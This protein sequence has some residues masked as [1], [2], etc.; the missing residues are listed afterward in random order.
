M[1]PSPLSLLWP[2]ILIPRKLYF[3]ALLGNHSEK[4]ATKKADCNSAIIWLNVQFE[5]STDPCLVWQWWCSGTLWS[6][7]RCW[8]TMPDVEIDSITLIS[9]VLTVK[10]KRGRCQEWLQYPLQPW[11]ALFPP[12]TVSFQKPGG[13]AL[14]RGAAEPTS[15]QMVKRSADVWSSLLGDD[16][17]A[18]IRTTKAEET[19]LKSQCWTAHRVRRQFTQ[20]ADSDF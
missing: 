10:R 12:P 9:T 6:L 2:T 15:S 18:K 13:G 11:W 3:S 20:W 19:S 17:A 14:L 5:M 4:R 8:R 7:S 1:P 16:A